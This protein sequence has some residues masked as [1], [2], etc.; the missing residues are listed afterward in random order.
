MSSGIYSDS[1]RQLKRNIG[2]FFVSILL[3]FF[4]AGAINA[5]PFV[6]YVAYFFVA[7]ALTLGLSGMFLDAAYEKK[8]QISDIFSYFDRI[9]PATGLV[10]LQALYIGLWSMLFVIPGIV[11][12]FSY[13]MAMFIMRD[14]PDISPG[15]AIKE[16][17]A[18]MDGNKAK[19]FKVLIIPLAVTIGGAFL[20]ITVF[21]GLFFIPMIASMGASSSSDELGA[22][23]GSIFVTSMI[24]FYV[25]F[26][27]FY[28]FYFLFIMFFSMYIRLLMANFYKEITLPYRLGQSM[29]FDSGYPQNE[30]LG[31]DQSFQDNS[32]PMPQ[33]NGTVMNQN[34]QN[35]SAP[36]PQGNGMD[37]NQNPQTGN[38]TEPWNSQNDTVNTGGQNGIY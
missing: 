11:K 34:F 14:N 38:A 5:V 35:N 26:F 36:M 17:M 37:M 18:L 9:M 15:D 23:T 30:S 24:M 12:W 7:S 3:V 28:V 4:V 16:S 20:I 33:G 6:G 22:S 29:G 13:S 27:L 25:G 32:A 31:M 19:L 1:F 2:P 8:V 10:F 21:A